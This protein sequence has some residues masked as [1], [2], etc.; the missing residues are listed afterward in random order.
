MLK[1][2]AEMVENRLKEGNRFVSI[3]VE[4]YS[5]INVLRGKVTE[6]NNL[7]LRTRT[8]AIVLKHETE[9]EKDAREAKTKKAESAIEAANNAIN[10]FGQSLDTLIELGYKI[11]ERLTNPVATTGSKSP[12]EV[13]QKAE[14]I[15]VAMSS[16]RM[17]SQSLAENI[18]DD[19]DYEDFKTAITNC[20]ELLD[21]L[22]D[23]YKEITDEDL[24]SYSVKL[25]IEYNYLKKIIE[26]QMSDYA[27]VPEITKATITQMYDFNQKV[28]SFAVQVRK[29]LD[30]YKK[31]DSKSTDAKKRYVESVT[32]TLASYDNMRKYYTKAERIR[33]QVE[34]N[35]SSAKYKTSEYYKIERDWED[36]QEAMSSLDSDASELSSC[37][38]ALK[39]QLEQLLGQ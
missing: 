28:P 18:K 14:T 39:S 25:T 23:V 33:S 24:A 16:I 15:K 30:E 10:S 20:S 4:I 22:D 11:K 34:R 31:I 2:Y 6:L 36:I 3:F 7:E 12:Q 27:S 21:D 29:Y 35:F 1:K 32:R 8:G 17:K 37:V 5:T 38:E 13:E 9:S 26:N 19:S